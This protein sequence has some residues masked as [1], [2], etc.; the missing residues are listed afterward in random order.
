LELYQTLFV[1]AAVAVAFCSEAVVGFGATLFALAI[2]GFAVPIDELLPTVVPLNVGL[3]AW[4]VIRDFHKVRPAYLLRRICPVLVAGLPA[5]FLIA[6]LT[7]GSDKHLLERLFGIFVL[8][9]G[10]VELRRTLRN[11][12]SRVQTPSVSARAVLNE[13]MSSPIVG[14]PSDAQHRHSGDSRFWGNGWRIRRLGALFL[15]GIAHGLFASGGPMVVYVAA[16]DG[17]PQVSF[18]STLALLWLVV[19]SVMVVL[20]KLSGRISAAT[21]QNWIFLL[22]AVLFG[23]FVGEILSK[24]VNRSTFEKAVFTTLCLAGFALAL[25]A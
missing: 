11:T 7:A 19:N 22:P 15:A 21:I 20:Y 12:D 25:K 9:V 24:K 18:R 17:L 13:D 6:L 16:K 3:S 5:G 14:L 4:I 10:L 23:I 8:A 2:A 1:A